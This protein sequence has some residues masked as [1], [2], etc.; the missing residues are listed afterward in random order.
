MNIDLHT[1]AFLFPGQGAQRLGMGRVL[2]QKDP[3]AAEVFA[4]ADEILAFSLSQLCWE[5]P[6]EI[7]NKTENAQP[8]L[9]THSV[10]VLRALQARF[11]GLQPACAAG[12]S[13]GEFT[14][15]VAAE[16]LSFEETLLLVQERG[17]AMKQAGELNPGGMLAALG[18]D[19]PTA[20]QACLKA[21][22]QTGKVVGI[23]NDNC[24]GQVVIS[25][26]PEALAAAAEF[27]RESGIRRL[28]P[29]AVSIAGH[30]SLLDPA[31]TRLNQALLNTPVLDPAFPIIG[32][33][34]A[35]PLTNAAEISVDLSAQLTSR[36]RWTESMQAIIA[37]GITT[38]IE[39][40]T[41]QVL[42]GLLKRIDRS[43][44]SIPI[45]EPDSFAALG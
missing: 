26:E 20:E 38:F 12:H 33:V 23:A 6:A 43:V 45:D 35:A 36:V 15:L 41:G 21:T 24:P 17:L 37:S 2:A 31:Q 1:T 11:P 4:C 27:L 7:L 44:R 32:N 3:H 8:A 25:G 42:T 10:A 19:I 39:L 9:L 16:A 13:L 28:V 5:G 40:G 30:S 29:L 18:A 34:N 14:A 22:Q